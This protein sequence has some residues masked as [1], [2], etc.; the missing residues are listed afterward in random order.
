ML[1]C[2]GFSMVMTGWLMARNAEAATP[3]V[4][5]ENLIRVHV[6]ANSDTAEDQALKLQVRD[7]VMERLASRLVGVT[8]A[9]EAEPV[10]AGALRELENEASRVIDQQ[11]FAYPV[12]AELGWFEFPDKSAGDIFL[13]AGNYKALRVVI[14]QGQGANFWCLL[15]PSFCYKLYEV[16]PKPGGSA[17]P[18]AGSNHD[19]RW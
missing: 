4:A 5:R 13:P 12:R 17:D 6:I 19:S 18:G 10:I 11:G 2:L 3:V 16:K 1:V 7:A 14:G 8:T 15:Y 9:A